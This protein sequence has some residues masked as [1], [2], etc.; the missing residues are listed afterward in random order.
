MTLHGYVGKINNAIPMLS[1]SY[2]AYLWATL[3]GMSFDAK[4][5]QE[6]RNWYKDQ[7]EKVME[8]LERDS[9]ELRQR[10]REIVCDFRM[11]EIREHIMRTEAE[12]AC[13]RGILD[14]WNARPE[15]RERIS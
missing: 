3:D 11:S 8:F 6:R 10:D 12:F 4:G 7:H 9:P 15:A 14:Q 2:A 1:E 5:M 13:Y